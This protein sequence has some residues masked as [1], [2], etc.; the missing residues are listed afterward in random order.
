MIAQNVEEL[1]G[2]MRPDTDDWIPKN[3]IETAELLERI[4]SGNA[5]DLLRFR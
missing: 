2:E 4:H 5:I 3:W 1:W